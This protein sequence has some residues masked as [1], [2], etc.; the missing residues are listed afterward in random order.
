MFVQDDWRVT[1][2]PEAPLRRALR[3]LRR[4]RGRRRTRRSTTS[5]D[6]EVDKN[7]FG[8]A[9][10]PGVD[11]GRRP[12]HGRAR[13]HRHD[14]RPGAARHLRAGAASTTAP[15]PRASATFTAR[16]GR[17]AGLPGVLSSRRRAP[18]RHAQ[19]IGRRSRLPGRAHLAEQRPVSSAAGR[20]TTRCRSAPR[21]CK[22][23]QPAGRQQHQPDQPDRHAGRRPPD[24]Q[25]RGQRRTRVDPR[26]NAINA[27][28][29]ARRLHLQELT[30]QLAAPHVE[31]HAVRLRLHARQ[32]RGQRADHRRA[33][34]A[35]RRRPHRPDE[36]RPRQGPERPRPAPH[37]HRQHRRAADAS[38]ST[39]R[40]RTR[41][42]NDNQC[43]RRDAVRQ[44][45]PVNLAQQPAS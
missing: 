32:E 14:V 36:P 45:H 13:Q 12:P 5:R 43:R 33:V 19:S 30:L 35:G 44:R 18:R 9:P 41:S 21:T 27:V 28:A 2:G 11:A 16:T 7:N 40:W 37:L 20:A 3:P 34:G 8:A 29:V 6:F 23:L 10:R 39:A 4:A 1:L 26:Y 24:L 15:T 25:H 38:T 42:L 17:R 22:R 31:R